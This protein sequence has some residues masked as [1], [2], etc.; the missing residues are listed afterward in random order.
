MV[1]A[2]ARVNLMPRNKSVY[3]GTTKIDPHQT[4]GEVT[5]ELVRAGATS[6]NTDY[7]DG[8]IAGLR[9]IMRV[10]GKDVLFD[11]PIR[12]EPVLELLG[13]RDVKQAERVA[14]RQ[15]LRWVQAQNA[16]IAMKMVDPAEVY[17]AYVVADQSTGKTLYSQLLG[18]GFKQLAAPGV[19]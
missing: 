9:W 2:S 3:M 12:V 11:M 15:L 5:R 18:N 19:G 17:L 8:S 10:G 1:V 13:G 4:A 6:V 7:H 16:M 14:W